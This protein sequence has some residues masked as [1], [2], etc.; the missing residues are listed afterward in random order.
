MY[1][2]EET[3]EKT[4]LKRQDPDPQSSLGSKDPDPDLFQNVT[5]PEHCNTVT[6]NCLKSLQ[7]RTFYRLFKVIFFLLLLQY[8]YM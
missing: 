7:K 6:Y 4:F 1:L 5:D 2:S 8:S 3:S